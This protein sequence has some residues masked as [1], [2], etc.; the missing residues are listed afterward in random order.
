MV[1]G[2]WQTISMIGA[3]AMDGIRS[4]IT[5]NSG[6]TADVFEAYVTQQLAPSLRPGDIVVMDNLNVHKNERIM[7]AIEA[8]KSMGLRSESLIA[9]ARRIAAE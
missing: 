7:P 9:A 2:H 1:G 5:I 8:G 3:I 6:T 4:M